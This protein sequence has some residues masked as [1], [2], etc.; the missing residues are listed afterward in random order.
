MQQKAK[1][2]FDSVQ[3]S[4][5]KYTNKAY[6][7]QVNIP[8]SHENYSRFD[9][10]INRIGTNNHTA[11]KPYRYEEVSNYYDFE[12]ENEALQKT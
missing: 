11:S 5:A 8:F 7:S 4:L 10:D 12:A 2:E 6:K 3:K 9:Q 1:Q